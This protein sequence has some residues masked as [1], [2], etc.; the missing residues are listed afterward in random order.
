MAYF[1]RRNRCE[2]S[3]QTFIPRKEHC[4]RVGVIFGGSAQRRV[5]S[6][7]AYTLESNNNFSTS[8]YVGYANAIFLSTLMA[9]NLRLITTCRVGQMFSWFVFWY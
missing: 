1:L 7:L 2:M 9:L 4:L 8:H 5:F 3:F 6:T